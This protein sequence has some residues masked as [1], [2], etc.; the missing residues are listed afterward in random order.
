M[1][2]ASLLERLEAAER[3]VRR[4]HLTEA[5]GIL[6][7]LIRDVRSCC[8]PSPAPCPCRHLLDCLPPG[9]VVNVNVQTPCK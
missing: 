6:C 2:N 1:T 5:E 8:E 9:S 7:H 4:A 3:C